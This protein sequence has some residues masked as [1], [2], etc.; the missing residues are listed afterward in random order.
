MKT[1]YALNES[2]NS[3]IEHIVENMYQN[4]EKLIGKT[5]SWETLTTNYFDFELPD[6]DM[7][8]IYWVRMRPIWVSSLNKKFIEC[9][10]PCRLS[11][12][13]GYG[14]NLLIHGSAISD[15]LAKR[16]KRVTK[17]IQ[18]SINLFDDMQMAFPEAKKILKISSD[19][20]TETLFGILGRIDNSRLPTSQRNELKRII[21]K[22]LPESDEE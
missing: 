18:L 16:T 2:D 11:T 9:N 4:K 8:K 22:S 19:I 20:M 5:I 21:Q 13:Y 15:T 7:D 1:N 6:N 3:I 17:A 12:V 10:Y 14:V